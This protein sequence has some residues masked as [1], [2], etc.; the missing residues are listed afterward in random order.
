MIG[1]L[2]KRVA[3]AG[4]KVLVV[5][6]DVPIASTREIEVRNG[7]SVPLRLSR[8]LGL[9]G[10]LSRPR[11]MV[12]TF[13]QTLLKHGIPHFENFTATRGGSDHYRR[14]WRPSRG[15]CRAELGRHALDTRQWNGKL[16]IKGILRREDARMA[17]AVGADGIIVF[18]SCRRQLDGAIDR[19]IHCHPSSPRHPT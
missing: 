5:T 1:P 14:H 6:V 2:L 8:R 12:S 18:Q 10:G 4:I 17:E 9:T 11:W 15:P 13:A 3:A 19:S 7:F 16:V